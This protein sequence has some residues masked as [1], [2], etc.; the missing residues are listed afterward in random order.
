MRRIFKLFN[1]LILFIFI[2]PVALFLTAGNSSAQPEECFIET[3][4]VA[5]GAEGQE[6]QFNGVVVETGETF[7]F[8]IPAGDPMGSSG[9]VE[10]GTSHRITEAPQNG[11]VFGGIEC[12]LGGGL[13][14]TEIEGGW[15]EE[16][17]NPKLDTFCVITNVRV[18]ANI[19]TLSEWGMIAAAAGLGLIGV[20]FAVRR[21]RAVNS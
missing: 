15:I 2:V 8:F 14:I 18:P 11:W 16:C 6:F 9:F 3:T 1:C 5:P 10:E 12:E 19:P 4:K 20:F 7:T 13:N 17:V 21:R